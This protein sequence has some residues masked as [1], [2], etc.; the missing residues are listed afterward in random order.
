LDVKVSIASPFSTIASPFS[1]AASP[2]SAISAASA[3]YNV[4]AFS[5]APAVSAASAH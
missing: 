2:F 4:L 3:F 1:A 5:S